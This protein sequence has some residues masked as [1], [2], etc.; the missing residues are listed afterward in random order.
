M[1]KRILITLLLLLLATTLCYFFWGNNE[2]D[3]SNIQ[4]IKVAQFGDVFIYAPLYIADAKGFFAEEGLKVELI[5]TGG[6]DKTYAAV[7][8]GSATF[9]VADPAFAAIGQEK[10]IKG[11]V[12]GNIVNGVPF[13][14]ITKRKD[15]PEI[16]DA[17]MLEPYSVATFSAPSTAYTVQSI[18]YQNAR[19][20]PNIKQ[21]AFGGLIPMLEAGQAD[22]A[23]ELEP[24]VSTAISNNA[25]IVYSFA[26]QYPD[27]AFTGITTSQKTINERPELVQHFINSITKAERYI[28]QHPDSA[29]T[30]M[31]RLFPDINQK[32][33][34][35]AIYRLVNSNTIPQNAIISYDAWKSSLEIRKQMGDLKSIDNIE[36]FLDMSFAEKANN[37]IQ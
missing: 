21:G 28:H 15:I 1:N 9:G 36:S 29:T 11:K 31:C 17:K 30:Y 33:V 6:D 37:T 5:S 25:R 10:G 35:D 22:I 24:N 32:I 14:A 2:K 34:K 18:M 4:T 23:L 12:I 20:K 26:E 8:G 27:F 16:T 13:W 19:L 7:I 3:N